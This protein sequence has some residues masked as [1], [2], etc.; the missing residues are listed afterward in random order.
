[1]SALGLNWQQD[2]LSS[3]NTPSSRRQRGLSSAL[4]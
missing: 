2:R 1:M 3:E 4:T